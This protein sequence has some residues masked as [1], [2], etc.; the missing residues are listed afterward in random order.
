M[1]LSAVGHIQKSVNTAFLVRDVTLDSTGHAIVHT[2]ET[3]SAEIDD[4]AT[5][6]L[7]Q[8]VA[9][10]TYSETYILEHMPE[11]GWIVIENDV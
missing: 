5:G 2:I 4:A 11:D 3:W 10:G 9:P 1:T 6:G 8:R 7:L